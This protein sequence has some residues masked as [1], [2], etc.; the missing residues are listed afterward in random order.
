MPLHMKAQ[1]PT[2]LHCVAEPMPGTVPACSALPVSS[3][4]PV[5]L[6]ST[7]PPPLSTFPCT[8]CHGSARLPI[9]LPKSRLQQAHGHATRG[10]SASRLDHTELVPQRPLFGH[11]SGQPLI[12]DLQTQRAKISLGAN[13]L[14]F[15][16]AV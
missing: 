4:L 1:S 2:Y 3:N 11:S 7:C 14:Q 8:A 13:K 5:S 6:C 12:A 10:M 15:K 9:R 16:Q